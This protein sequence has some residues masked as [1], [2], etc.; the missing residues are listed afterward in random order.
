MA[1]TA[2]KKV[3]A[4]RSLSEVFTD[5]TTQWDAFVAAHNGTKKKNTAEARKALGE[6]KKLV[7]PYRAQS[8]AEA[9]AAKN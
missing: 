9:K 8:V 7:T 1:K 6:I 5:L 4:V 3:K 2:T